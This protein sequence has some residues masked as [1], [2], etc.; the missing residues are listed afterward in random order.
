MGRYGAKFEVSGGNAADY[1]VAGSLLG[2]A[3]RSLK[4][5]QRDA[6]LVIGAHHGCHLGHWR[7][8]QGGL[9]GRRLLHFSSTKGRHGEL[10]ATRGEV[11]RRR[12]GRMLLLGGVAFGYGCSGQLLGASNMLFCLIARVINDVRANSC[13]ICFR[14]P[15]DMLIELTARYPTEIH[16]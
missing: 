2:E 10:T 14:R 15:I 11:G 7:G 8:D 6:V 13:L 4:D 5:A 1:S 16:S 9:F 12:L 3:G